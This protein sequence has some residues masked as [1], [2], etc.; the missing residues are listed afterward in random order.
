MGRSGE[1]RQRSTGRLLVMY[2]A[3]TLVPVI[4]LGF[5]LANSYQAEANRRGLAEGRSEALLMAQTAVQPLLD[6]RPLSQG[7]SAVETSGLRHLVADAVRERDVL[8]LRVRNLAGQVVFSGD[9][10]GIRQK[11]EDEALSAA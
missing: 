1:L 2:G 9:G 5:V 8:R 3:I 4:L 6:G 11:P 7:L 10:S